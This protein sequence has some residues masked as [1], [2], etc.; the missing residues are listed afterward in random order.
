MKTNVVYHDFRRQ[1]RLE[2][3]QA[4]QLKRKPEPE[5]VMRTIDYFIIAGFII[6]GLW[7]LPW[8]SF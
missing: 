1:S 6:W 4:R 5:R 7:A 8:G 3:L 2:Q